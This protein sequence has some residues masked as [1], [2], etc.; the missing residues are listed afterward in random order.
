MVG[1]EGIWREYDLFENGLNKTNGRKILSE[2]SGAYMNARALTRELR[3]LHE[4]G[5]IARNTIVGYG[6]PRARDREQV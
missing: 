4:D 6:L 5:K 3:T 2:R 1:I